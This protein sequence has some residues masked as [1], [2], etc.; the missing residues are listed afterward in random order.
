MMRRLRVVDDETEETPPT[1]GKLRVAFATQDMTNVNAHFGSA[2]KL[3]IYE[4]SADS[5]QFIEAM[6]FDNISD[7]SGTHADEGDDRLGQ[8]IE[9]LRGVNILFVLAIGG[10]AAARIV[11]AKI[12]PLK[13]PAPEP[14]ADVI[15][16]L[17]GLI[18]GNPP[19]W[20]RRVLKPE[21]KSL[22]FLED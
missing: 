4:V 11:N 8:K 19:P 13:L 2:K 10:P 14:I 22:D 15:G 18:K 6:A 3:A 21:T 17:Q 1:T 12:H 7:E 5:A 16:R 20:L 9:G